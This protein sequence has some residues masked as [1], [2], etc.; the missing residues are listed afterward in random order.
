MLAKKYF[1]SW[2]TLAW[3]SK[4][5][6]RAKV[7]RQIFAQSI[8]RENQRQTR[9]D[10]ELEEILAAKKEKELI[11]TEQVSQR[12]VHPTPCS[13]VN[14]AGEGGQTS[15]RKRKSIHIDQ[16]KNITVCTDQPPKIH[17]SHKRSRTL[18]STDE[19]SV[20]TSAIPA[21]KADE[22]STPRFGSFL[23]AEKSSFSGSSGSQ[24][25]RPSLSMQVDTTCTDYFRLKALE[26]DPDTPLIPETKS[27]LERKRQRQAEQMAQSSRLRASSISS[28]SGSAKPA[29]WSDRVK[30]ASTIRSSPFSAPTN[31]FDRLDKTSA[32]KSLP[33][34][35]TKPKPT[36][37]LARSTA[38]SPTFN[39]DDE[40]DE[41]L[42]R[43]REVK[44][45]MTDQT[46]WFKT[47]AVEM[48]KEVEVQAELRRS[49]S[50]R[51]SASQMSPSAKSGLATANGYQYA[52][53]LV[54]TGRILSRTEQR[55]RRTGGHGLATKPLGG[56][57]YLAVAMSR[58]TKDRLA[59]EAP[60]GDATLIFTIDNKKR[61]R[62]DNGKAVARDTN[63]VTLDPDEVKEG[64]L[65]SRG[66]EAEVDFEHDSF[67]RHRANAGSRYQREES[68]RDPFYVY[69]EPEAQCDDED[70]EVEADDEGSL[71]DGYDAIVD[72]PYAQTPHIYPQYHHQQ[73]EDDTEE[74]YEDDEEVEEDAEEEEEED[75]EECYRSAQPAGFPQKNDWVRRHPSATP[76]T[77]QER[78]SHSLTPGIGVEM[79][80]V[81]SGTGAS[82]E[83]ALVLDSD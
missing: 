28:S 78:H 80:R 30:F 44:A 40:E 46:N 67:S 52:P 69:A 38:N 36:S 14:P 7:R 23:F 17:K 47:Q 76:E 32:P 72:E 45:V 57:D 42:C 79:S 19:S 56:G 49:A 43:V 59:R 65:E 48:E 11:Q 71:E 51:D 83:D 2:K 34:L 18:R 70:Y 66:R 29:E 20:A 26:I 3:R 41:L 13:P 4:L 8:R 1:S 37:A 53:N 61:E 64:L 82:A 62:Q 77:D 39:A 5:N 10:A 35:G 12:L 33:D 60:Q 54:A 6:R 55:I 74:L 9:A 75:G 63:H 50:S 15:S 68:G 31:L 21:A 25:R 81:T 16:T 58:S 27:S 24:L 22:H 73:Y